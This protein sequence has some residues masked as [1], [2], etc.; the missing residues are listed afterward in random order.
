MR[1]SPIGAPASR[2]SRSIARAQPVTLGEC[3][4]TAALPAE[5]AAPANRS[6]C[7]NGKFHGITANTT[8]SGS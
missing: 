6:T 1:N 7:Q 3:L 8:P 5:R 4:S 2:N